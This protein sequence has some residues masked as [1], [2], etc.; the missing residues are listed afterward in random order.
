[1]SKREV[2]IRY[3]VD[4]SNVN[5]INAMFESYEGVAIVRVMDSKEGI[6]EVYTSSDFEDFVDLIVKSL[7]E[8]YSIRMKEIERIYY[9][10]DV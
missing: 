1:M 9:D 6:L 5:I 8:E 7:R 2:V 3:I 10:T 4:R